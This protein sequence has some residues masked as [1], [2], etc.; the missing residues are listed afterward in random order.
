M[1]R[2]AK[3]RSLLV[4]ESQWWELARRRMNVEGKERWVALCHSLTVGTARPD[5]GSS[6]GNG[7]QRLPSPEA[8]RADRRVNSWA[9]GGFHFSPLSRRE[10]AESCR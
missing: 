7:D 4:A 1:R 5:E 10:G 8:R 2:Q 9:T 3:D 6:A